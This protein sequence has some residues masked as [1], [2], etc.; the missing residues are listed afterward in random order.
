[1]VRLLNSWRESPAVPVN[2]V[3]RDPP[4]AVHKQRVKDAFVLHLLHEALPGD[5]Q[6]VYHYGKDGTEVHYFQHASGNV[7]MVKHKVKRR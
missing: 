1:M 3:P 7:A 2:W 5:W 4:G 6:K